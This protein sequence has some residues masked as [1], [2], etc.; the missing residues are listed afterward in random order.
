[1][2]IAIAVKLIERGIVGEVPQT[3]LDLGAGNGTFTNALA[4]LLA[5]GSTIYAI[6]R[7]ESALNMIGFSHHDISLVTIRKDFT[8]EELGVEMPDG[9]LM[10]NSLHFVADKISFV[11]R[12]KKTVNTGGSIIVVEYDSDNGNQWVPYPVSFASLQKLCIEL[13]IPSISKI[14]DTPSVYQ[15]RQIYSSLLTL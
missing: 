7:D 11:N 3:W 1:M 14:G 9:I 4:T 2:D 8:T 13:H 10:A 6:D 15:S 5:P 12:I